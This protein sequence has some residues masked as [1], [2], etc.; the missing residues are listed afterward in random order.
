MSTFNTILDR[1]PEEVKENTVCKARIIT[2]LTLF[3][4]PALVIFSA[5]MY[6][7]WITTI[8]Q[9]L[10]K[11]IKA[12]VKIIQDRQ[13]HKANQDKVEH[14]ELPGRVASLQRSLRLGSDG[15]EEEDMPE[16][17]DAET[18][19]GNAFTAGVFLGRRSVFQVGVFDDDETLEVDSVWSDAFNDVGNEE[20]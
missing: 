13:Q 9:Y 7:G 10:I 2:Y 12:V 3:T 14:I 4:L 8:T 15:D 5:N 18:A 11:L 1:Y 19:V 6:I 17:D 16:D 20:Y